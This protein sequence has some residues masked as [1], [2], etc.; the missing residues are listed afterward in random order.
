MS[1]LKEIAADQDKLLE[2]AITKATENAKRSH[3]IVFS[4]SSNT[5]L[6]LGHNSGTMSGFSFRKGS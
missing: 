1:A 4:G 3:H 2:Q 5:R 6:Q